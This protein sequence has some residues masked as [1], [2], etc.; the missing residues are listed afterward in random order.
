VKTAMA[1]NKTYTGGC[2]CG[3]VRYEVSTD[4]AQVIECNCSICAKKGSLLT[5]VGTDQFK[6][7][8]GEG[9][10]SDYQFNKNVVHHVFCKTC[11][12]HSFGHGT[13]PGGKEMR[14][15]NVRCLDGVEPSTLKLTPFDGKNRL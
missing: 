13:G 6:L 7:L 1:T 3:K 5:F 10:L 12:I 2:H 11:G 8:S 9:E 15:I 14:A 4:L